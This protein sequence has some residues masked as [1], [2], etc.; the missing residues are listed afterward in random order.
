[1]ERFSIDTCVRVYHVY[2]DIWESS[3]G[4]SLNSCLVNGKTETM[5]ILSTSHFV[6]VSPAS[7]FTHE[8]NF[9]GHHAV[10]HAHRHVLVL[11]RIL[12][13]I[14]LRRAKFS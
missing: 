4:L 9:V 10:G 7:P 2:S 5:L 3:V 11:V 8:T 6:V 1:M 14:K 13:V 12:V